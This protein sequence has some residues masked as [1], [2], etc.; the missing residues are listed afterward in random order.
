MNLIT[1]ELLFRGI[2]ELS[3][4]DLLVRA[5]DVF[6]WCA[7][8]PVDYRGSGW[9]NQAIWDADRE[10]ARGQHRLL[11]FKCGT[12]RQARVAWGLVHHADKVRT[13]AKLAGWR[14]LHWDGKR[15]VW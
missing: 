7:R 5:T 8:L 9:N 1:A 10:E 13:A 15:W 14:E 12:T 6:E 4:D 3:A 2:K 11:K